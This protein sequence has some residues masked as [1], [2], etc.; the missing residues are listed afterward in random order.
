MAC[1]AIPA[2]DYV[3]IKWAFGDFGLG[4]FDLYAVEEI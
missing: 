2:P 1:Q 3:K 4:H